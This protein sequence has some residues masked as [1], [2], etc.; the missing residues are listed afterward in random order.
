MGRRV[1]LRGGSSLDHVEFIGAEREVTVDINKKTAIVHDGIKP[2]GY[3]LATE[4]QIIAVNEQLD[5]IQGDKTIEGSIL[6]SIQDAVNALKDGADID[7]DTLSELSAAL[8]A[9]GNESAVNLANSI[10]N[11]RNELRDGSNE[12]MDTFKEVETELNLIIRDLE[13]E[14]TARVNA[15]KAINTRLDTVLDK[16]DCGTL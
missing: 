5:V 1:K 3:P 9:N 13:S 14:A 16:I 7:V 11:L 10:A 6:K 2:G 12:A 15:D 8:T 4:R